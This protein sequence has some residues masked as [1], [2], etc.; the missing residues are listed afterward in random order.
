MDNLRI[1]EAVRTPPATALKPISGGRLNGKTD[2]N[3]MWRIKRLTELFGPCGEGWTYT[4]TKREYVP[5]HDGEIAVFVDI[6]LMYKTEGGEWS[7]AIPGTG[8]SMYV[9]KERGG[10]YTDDEAPKKALTD[11]LSVACKALGIGADVYWDK[12]ATK[13]TPAPPRNTQPAQG[14]DER[15]TKDR[16]DE[17]YL[18]AASRGFSETS[19]RKGI[20][21]R[22]NKLPESMDEDEYQAVL[23]GYMALAEKAG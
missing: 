13:Y 22:Y 11:A 18:V 10:L 14:A 2:I 16:L 1:Y 9:V 6:E 4:P 17:L 20:L 8:G 21:K 12:D 5:G 19:V 7:L 3:P 15:P 23:G